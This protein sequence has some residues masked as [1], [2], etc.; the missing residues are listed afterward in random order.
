MA[1][2]IGAGCL[3]RPDCR[4][5]GHFWWQQSSG[6]NVR[7]WWRVQPIDATSFNLAKAGV[8]GADCTEMVHATAAGLRDLPSRNGTL[9]KLLDSLIQI[10]ANFVGRVENCG[11]IPRV[12]QKCAAILRLPS[13]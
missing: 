6:L 12:L 7:F 8:D 2:S 4:A 13:L 10:K 1:D 9:A 5:A 11:L 3:W